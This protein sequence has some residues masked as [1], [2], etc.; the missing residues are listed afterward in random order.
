M[1]KPPELGRAIGDDKL[2]ARSLWQVGLVQMFT[3]PR[4]ALKTLDEA[5][6]LARKA[7]LHIVVT[8][9]LDF[10]AV[11]YLN[12]GRPEEAFGCAEAAVREGE[13]VD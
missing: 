4:E 3:D 7:G 10:K 1:A 12:L 2:V 9:S 11:A 6:A 5:I 8:D 13:E